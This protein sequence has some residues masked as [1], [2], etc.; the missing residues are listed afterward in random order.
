MTKPPE[1][2]AGDGIR[3]VDWTVNPKVKNGSAFDCAA[4]EISGFTTLVVPDDA[5]VEKG[6]SGNVVQIKM[7]KKLHFV[8]HPPN[9]VNP[10][11]ARRNMGCAW[12]EQ[13]DVVSLGTY[14]EWDSHIEG[15]ASVH[16]TILVPPTMT[17][18]QESGLSG[19]NSV[20]MSG[21]IADYEKE[22]GYWYAPGAPAAGWTKIGSVPDEGSA[23]AEKTE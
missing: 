9:P 13:G 7:R 20:A 3:T 6:S 11:V 23:A 5:V 2:P 14:G 4:L 10:E 21:N 12:K 22:P 1:E 19:E 8:G 16:L 17:V 18:K 15:G